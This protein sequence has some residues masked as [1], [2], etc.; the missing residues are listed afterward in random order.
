MA[1][2]VGDRALWFVEVVPGSR[3]P[4]GPVAGLM[5]GKCPGDR[6]QVADECPG[7][8]GKTARQSLVPGFVP[9][10]APCVGDPPLDGCSP[11]AAVDIDQPETG[12]LPLQMV[13][14]ELH[15]LRVSVQFAGVAEVADRARYRQPAARRPFGTGLRNGPP[16]EA[17]VPGSIRQV[18]L[19]GI[20]G[21][22]CDIVMEF[23]QGA[24][25][26]A[27]EVGKQHGRAAGGVIAFRNACAAPV[28][29]ALALLTQC[30]DRLPGS[31]QVLQP[32]AMG[33]WI[34]LADRSVA[35]AGTSQFLPASPDRVDGCPGQGNVSLRGLP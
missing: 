17:D 32:P 13:R 31:A 26:Q 1:H 11:A 7:E 29:G 20:R 19:G 33:R 14:Q 4:R 3:V 12:P 2:K 35:A 34:G 5:L 9:K 6:V 24:C 18:P 15:G 25:R 10:E 22:A 16:G 8:V 28:P 21:S 23:L 30:R 27:V